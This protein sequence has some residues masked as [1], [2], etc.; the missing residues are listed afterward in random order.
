MKKLYFFWALGTISEEDHRRLDTG[1]SIGENESITAPAML[2]VMKWGEYDT[3]KEEINSPNIERI[4]MN[5]KGQPVVAGYLTISEGRK[6]QVKRML[7][8]VGCYVIYLKRTAIGE[9][10]LDEALAKGE[11]R[12][13]TKEEMVSLLEN[14]KSNCQKLDNTII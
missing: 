2:E 7:K 6:H 3:L 4:K 9:V 13:L 14:K 12:E 10:S 5:P 11:Y 8:A 1:I